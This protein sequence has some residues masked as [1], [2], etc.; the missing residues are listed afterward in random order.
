MKIWWM[1]QVAS[2][3]MAGQV[4]DLGKMEVRGKIRGPEVQVIDADTMK[5]KTAKRYAQS[6]LQSM[7][8][9]LLRH[10]PPTASRKESR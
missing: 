6:Q 9:S 10:T 8:E 4:I 2:A 5:D 7:E 1:L 3:A